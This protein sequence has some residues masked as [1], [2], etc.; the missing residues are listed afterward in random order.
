M[1]INLTPLVDISGA[2]GNNKSKLKQILSTWKERE[3]VICEHVVG[4]VRL[5][6]VLFMGTEV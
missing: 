3:C 1:K 4:H 6:V 2:Y 5:I